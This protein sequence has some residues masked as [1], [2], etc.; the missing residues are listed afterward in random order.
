MLEESFK[1][2]NK[3]VASG[4]VIVNDDLSITNKGNI[5]FKRLYF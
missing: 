4:Q 1:K 3:Q 5:L 2:I